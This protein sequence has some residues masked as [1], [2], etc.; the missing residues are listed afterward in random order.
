M[1]YGGCFI[2]G[3][4]TLKNITYYSFTGIFKHQLGLQNLYRDHFIKHFGL[5]LNQRLRF[6]LVFYGFTGACFVLGFPTLKNITS[7]NLTGIF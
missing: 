3:F 7:Y 2:F 1:F 6:D 4:F 5:H